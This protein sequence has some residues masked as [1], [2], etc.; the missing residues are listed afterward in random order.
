VFKDV[1]KWVEIRRRVLNKEISK[2][3]ACR[4]YKVPWRTLERILEHVEPPGY[5]LKQPRQKRKLDPFL[6][7]I[8]EMLEGD[9]QAPRKQRHTAQRIFDRLVAEHKYD[10]G[11]TIVKDA[12]RAWRHGQAEVFVP[13]S[14]RPGTAQA[15]FGEV[16]VI[17]NG[18]KT[19]VAFFVITLPYSDTIFCQVFP[20]ECTETFQEGHCRAFEFFDGVPHRI[21]YDNSK[22]AVL[23]IVGGRGREATREFLRLESHYLFEHHFCLVRRPNEKGHVENLLGF[24]RRNFLVPLPEVESLE[25]LNAQLT[26]LCRLDLQRKV[27]GK[28]GPKETL[29]VEEQPT[30]LAIPSQ[31]FEARRVETPTANSLSLVRFHGNDYSVPTAYAHHQVTV[32]GGIEE[33]R[34]AVD[35]Q[36]VARHPRHWGQ[37]HTEFNPIHYLALLERKPGAFDYARPLEDWNL[38]VCFT[39]LRRRQEGVLKKLATR[40][41]IKVLRLLEHATLPQLTAAVDYAL[42]IG[43]T[44]SDAVGLI[45]RSQQEPP[46]DLFCLD[47]RPQLQGVRVPLPNLQAYRSLRVGA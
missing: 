13:L 26:E 8:H 18:V 17:L 36:L 38:P 46:V 43:A 10:G 44:S 3:Q 21:S 5:Q 23:K 37:E 4:D 12:V 33:V 25:S 40:E 1:E 6:P 45:L 14:H 16:T 7:I 2:R 9:R 27:R 31:R 19:K 39:V 30:L 41:F 34:I 24:A 32:I 28:P 22:I 35:N 47:G 11:Y 29:L 15:D 42:S 20:K